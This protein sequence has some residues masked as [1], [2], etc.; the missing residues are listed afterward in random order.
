MQAPRRRD[1]REPLASRVRRPS[2]TLLLLGSAGIA[3]VVAVVLLV[4]LLGS[5]GGSSS[6]AGALRDAGCT[7]KD[8]PSVP[9]KHVNSLTAKVKWS[10]FPPTSG[11]H[12]VQPAVWG[13]YDS[14]LNELQVVH[15]LEHGGLAIQWGRGVPAAEVEKLRSFYAESPNGLLL[16]P[17]PRLENKIAL[18]AWNEAPYEGALLS[19]PGRGTGRLAEC[20]RFDEDGFSKFRDSYRAKGPERFPLDQLTP[21]T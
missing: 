18:T 19:K 20:T 1:A 13:E 21:G 6:A 5:D 7:V 2:R 4:V 14:P 10:S 17:L 16:A 12:Y 3:G 8:Y 11:P 9:P 15:N